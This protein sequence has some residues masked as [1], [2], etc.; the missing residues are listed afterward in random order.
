M[1]PAKLE[2]LVPVWQERL[3]LAHWTIIVE[4]DGRHIA[5]DGDDVAMRIFRHQR[6]DDAVLE[7]APWM[8]GDG[9]P[10]DVIEAAMLDDRLVEQKLVHELL[11][12]C[13]RDLANII[14]DDLDGF[15]QR[16]AHELVRLGAVRA[17]EAMVDRLAKTL[18]AWAGTR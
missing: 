5:E 12:L 6:Y 7:V 16:D 14:E 13:S 11:H 8:V 2:A 15:L 10:P 3:G 4:V 9:Q 1:S 17:E 18:V